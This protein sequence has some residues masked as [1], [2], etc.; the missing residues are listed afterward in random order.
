MTEAHKTAILLAMICAIIF[1]MFLGSAFEQAWYE[2]R[3][4]VVK[5]E[6]TK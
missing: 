2:K 3:G 1:G 5:V 6:V 4:C